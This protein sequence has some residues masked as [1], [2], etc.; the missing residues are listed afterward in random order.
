MSNIS[1]VITALNSRLEAVFPSGSGYFRL[2]DGVNVG[3]N[4]NEH[5]TKGFGMTPGPAIN[6]NRQL[7]KKM[8]VARDFIVTNT[9]EVFSAPFDVSSRLT[10]EKN[11]FEDQQLLLADIEATP[12]LGDSSSVVKAVYTA[13]NGIETIFDDSDSHLML[14][15]IIN[16]EY[17]EDI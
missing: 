5:L 8:S 7:D 16:I 4:A 9:R 2:H 10:T 15:T 11:L 17:F 13:D 12:T 14:R 1:G 6:T 3:Q